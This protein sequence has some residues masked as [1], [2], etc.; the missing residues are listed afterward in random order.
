MK[1]ATRGVSRISD[2]VLK[3]GSGSWVETACGRRLLDFTCGIGVVNTGHCHPRVVAAAQAQCGKMIH[4]QLAIG[5][6]EPMIELID[7]LTPAMPH[8]TLDSF[9]F[10]TTG[11]EAVENAVK[12]ARTATGRQHVIVFQGGYHGRSA[13]TMAMTTSSTVYHAG[14]GP[15]P[16][17]VK[18]APFPYE[19]HGVTTS[20]CLEQ[21]ELLLRQQTTPAE[22]AAVVIEPVLGEGGYVPAPPAFLAGVRRIC[23]AH[24]LLLVVDEVQTG[25]GRTGR[26]F[27]CDHEPGLRPDILTMAKGLASGFPLAA[28]ASRRE[29]FDTL[30]PGSMGGTYAGN[31][32]ACA[33][34]VETQRV[35]RD[36]GLVANAAAQGGRMQAAL[37]A[38]G[39]TLGADVVR[40]VRGLGCMVGVELAATM[41]KGSA[42]ALSQA[43]LARGLLLLPCSVYETVRLIPPLNVS[44]A[45]VDEAVGIFGEALEAVAQQ[46]C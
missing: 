32:V 34:A 46:H 5:Y 30:T 23:D 27:A 2:Y 25:F 19:L 20:Y 26:L 14:F 33:A 9:F 44:A 35:I 10:C 3:S 1:A 43:C 36:E 39:Q 40:D 17:G 7:E 22:V 6:H 29:L 12:L 31:A 28:I 8:P 21:L 37:R 42:K 18:V 4:A 45:E 41:P 13:L 16:P 15:F 11:A 38:L 24:G